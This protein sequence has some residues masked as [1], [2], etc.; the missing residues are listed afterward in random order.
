MEA[1]Y[2]YFLIVHL[3]CAIIFLGFIF[4]D[5]VLF[6]VVRKQ[7]DSNIS[8]K[9]F[10]LISSRAIKIM[11]LCL[12]LL[13]ISGGAMLS[14]YV[15]SKVGF[16]DTTTQQ[17]LM[18]KVILALAIV[19]MVVVSLSYKIRNKPN[20]LAKIIHPLALCLGFVIVILAKLAFYMG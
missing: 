20:P 13:V 7:L 16:F 5:V 10:K 19:V 3:V 17:L 1:L 15:N 4:T 11:P 9:I 6:P 2:P 12:V 8:E 18:I 14:S